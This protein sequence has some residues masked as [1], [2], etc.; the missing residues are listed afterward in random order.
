MELLDTIREHEPKSPGAN[1]KIFNDYTD[2][3]FLIFFAPNYNVFVDD[4][5]EVFGD[6]W[7]EA[8]VKAGET[9]EATAAAMDR[10]QM[11]YGEFDFALTRIDTE[12][13]KY[14]AVHKDQWD[15]KHATPTANFYVRRRP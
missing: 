12:F 6:D 13:D 11:Q 2:G 9:P 1:A 7:L 3:G 8:F 5:C 10:W 14:F 15:L 4:R